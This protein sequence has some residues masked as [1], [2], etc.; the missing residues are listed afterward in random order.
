MRTAPALDTATAA[1]DT[2]HS[3]RDLLIFYPNTTLASVSP[4]AFGTPRPAVAVP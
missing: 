4:R 1:G 2:S 3:G